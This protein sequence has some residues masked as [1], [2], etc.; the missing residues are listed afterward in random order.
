MQVLLN[1]FFQAEGTISASFVGSSSLKV[2]PYFLMNQTRSVPAKNRMRGY[3]RDLTVPAR[4]H[5]ARPHS[6]RPHRN[7][8]KFLR[9]ARSSLMSGP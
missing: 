9:G 4:P 5:S 2:D 7:L 8:V 1:G 6:A 3:W